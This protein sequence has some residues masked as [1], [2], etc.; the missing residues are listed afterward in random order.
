MQILEAAAM[1]MC[2]GVRDALAL[3]HDVQD[4]ETVTIHGELVHNEDVLRDLD[5]RGF[6]RSPEDERPV[7]AT[8]RVLVT[9]HGVS[10]RERSRL[11]NAGKLVLD[12]TCPLVTKAHANALMLQAEGRRV[13]VIGKPGHVEVRGLT[14][15]L[16]DPIVVATAADVE[17]WGEPRLG[18]LCQ[19]TTPVAKAAAIR[20]AI[21]AAN[22]TSD[23]RFVDTICAPT[24]AR[25]EALDELI[26]RVDVLVA[27][28]GLGSN[29]T[30]ALAETARR[31]GV[32]AYH[33]DSAPALQPEWFANCST[34]GLTAG[35][36]TPAATIAAVR[37][38]LVAFGGTLVEAAGP[39]PRLAPNP[40]AQ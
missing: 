7:P 17:S 18:V 3:I 10:N 12:T 22:P 15:D 11:E 36:S 20:A 38:R 5:R 1:G 29:N 37:D 39:A 24:K 9:A 35:T 33:V 26:A 40:R 31:R 16:A 8:P 32:V 13:I 19:T 25:I 34:V 14:E 2:F 6:A 28:G 4:P 30:R 27:V 21:R 23:V